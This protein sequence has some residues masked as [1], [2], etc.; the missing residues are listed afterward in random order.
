MNIIYICK[1]TRDLS[2]QERC[3]F[4]QYS[5]VAEKEKWFKWMYEDNIYGDSIHVIAYNNN[6]VVGW[7]A[8]WRNDI[9]PGIVSYQPSNTEVLPEMRKKG[10]FYK[11]TELALNEI[12]DSLI[13]NFPNNNSLHG[14]LK[15]GWKPIKQNIGSLYL[16]TISN[17]SNSL[18]SKDVIPQEYCKWRFSERD[19][20]CYTKYKGQYF[21]VKKEN[22]RLGI[23]FPKVIGKI[24][25]QSSRFFQEI[26]LKI[27]F[28]FE[29]GK[30]LLKVRDG[31]FMLVVKEV[32][33]KYFKN[34]NYFKIDIL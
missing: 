18:I 13:Y 26:K 12:G 21:L 15:L 31:K 19:C 28:S 9:L 3:D 29:S 14:Y 8:F 4:M 6:K 7:R 30:G 5:S 23:K 32:Q 33:E 20:F 17:I 27:A 22:S 16:G 34:I 11:M 1:K 25:R 2:V 24:D 10:I